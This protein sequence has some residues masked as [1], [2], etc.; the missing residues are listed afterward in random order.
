MFG[1][2]PI[3]VC[4]VFGTGM[5]VGVLLSVGGVWV[6]VLVGVGLGEVVFVVF[7]AGCDPWRMFL[8]CALLILH[9]FW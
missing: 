3:D 6:V 5:V 8:A 7:D 1:V 9:W 4:V 2:G